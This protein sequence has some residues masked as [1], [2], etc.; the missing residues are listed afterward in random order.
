M[1]RLRFLILSLM[2]PGWLL[3]QPGPSLYVVALFTDKAMLEINGKQR[4]LSRGQTSPEGIRLIEANSSR[5]L[6]E[7]NGEELSLTPQ[8][9]VSTNF[10]APTA[11]EYRIVKDKS[12]H[13]RSQGQINGQNIN[14]LVDTG[15][16][17]IAINE[18]QA[19]KLGINY[20]SARQGR[21]QT[22]AGT[23]KGYAVTLDQVSLGPLSMRNVQATVLEGNAGAEAL[24]G[25]S[26]L[27]NLEMHQESNLML[28]KQK[29]P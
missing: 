10:V 1:K 17:S 8:T 15:A 25:M 18:T 29:Y 24:M 28:L 22:A 12:G 19:Q 3:A 14:F 11:R 21:V 7:V 5:A 4:L 27:K 16:T 26:F 6:V 9:R 2:L 20:K 13:F 23:V